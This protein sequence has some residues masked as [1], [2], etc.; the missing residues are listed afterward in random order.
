MPQPKS[1]LVQIKTR[2]TEIA[3]R[4]FL[5]SQP[6]GPRRDDAF[7]LLEMMRELSGEEPVMWGNSIIGFGQKR[8][9]SEKTG[10]E[11]DWFLV[12]LALRKS[13]ISVHL[14]I[15]INQH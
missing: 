7:I 13:N 1:K 14:A 10:R 8:Y 6:E 5:L 15:D 2:P 3:P 4:D 11:V 9:R 12:G